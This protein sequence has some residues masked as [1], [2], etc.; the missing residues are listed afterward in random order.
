MVSRTTLLCLAVFLTAQLA[1]SLPLEQFYP[2]GI[3]EGDTTMQ[4]TDDGFYRLDLDFPFPYFDT[5]Y[6]SIFISNNGLISFETAVS[7][8]TGDPFPLSNGIRMIAGYW[9]DVDTRSDP[10]LLA[11]VFYRE[12]TNESVL[13]RA[14]AEINENFPI[15]PAFAATQV[16]IT[17]YFKV[18]RYS[19]DYSARATFQIVLISDGTRSFTQL[20]YNELEWSG[21]QAGFNSGN[22]YN[23]FSL[24][25][26]LTP[27]VTNLNSLSN[28]NIPGMF[29]FRVDSSSV[30]QVRNN[31]EFTIAS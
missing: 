23:Y 12:T 30:Q 21:A 24:P 28:I 22:A 4:K 25:G 26:A 27:Q 7:D 31:S 11:T 9:G 15:R 16:V 5:N 1:T 13:A 18:G 2:F 19:A 17:T 29:A 8:Y 3:A 14:T 20:L 6:D 10:Q